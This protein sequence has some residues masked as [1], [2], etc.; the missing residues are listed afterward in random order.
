MKIRRFAA[1]AMAAAMTMGMLT[2]CG[3]SSSSSG[4]ADTTASSTSDASASADAAD[5]VQ[6]TYHYN[7]DGMEDKTVS[8][9]ADTRLTTETPERDGYVFL[10]WYTDEGLTQSFASGTKVSS[11]QDLYAKWGTGYVLEA[12]Y[13]DLSNFHGQGFS[14]GC[15]GAQAIAQDKA[16][17]G[18]SNGAY[19]T[20]MYN[21]GLS[22]SFDFTSDQEVDDATIILRLSAEMMDISISSSD[23]TVALNDTPL[24]YTTIDLTQDQPFEDYVVGTD[25]HLNE[26]ENTITLTT[27]NTNAMAGT[28]YATAPVIDC[29]KVVTTANIT[30]DAHTENMDKFSQD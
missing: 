24:N 11:N 16:N 3:S 15:D 1:M 14:G 2:G 7:A 8:Q 5:G 30:M 19:L 9:A 6:I 20:Y 26:G 28:M 27:N 17:L 13:V 21:N 23:F 29:V 4:T 12:E 22:V 10:G 18:A 25:C